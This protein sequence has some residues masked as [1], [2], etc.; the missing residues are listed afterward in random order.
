[1]KKAF[2]ITLACILLLSVAANAAGG[3]RGDVNGDGNINRQDRVFLARSLAGWDGYSAATDTADINGDGNVN[4]QDRV[5]LAR[6]LAGWAGYE[7][8]APDSTTAPSPTAEPTAEPTV[9]PTAEP[10]PEPTA[11]PTIEP[12]PTS[13]PEPII[14]P[15]PTSG[16]IDPSRTVYVSTRSHTVHSVNDCSGMKNYSEMTYAEAEAAGYKLCDNCW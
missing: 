13:T 6:A 4:R 8:S 11:E 10:T 5:Y 14:T 7:L 15:I 3:M 2:T 12:I 16:T 9:E 1:M